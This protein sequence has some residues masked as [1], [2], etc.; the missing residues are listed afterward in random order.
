[1][2]SCRFCDLLREAYARSDEDKRAICEAAL[3]VNYEYFGRYAGRDLYPGFPI[4]FCPVCGR[5]YNLEVDRC[6]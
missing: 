5:Q 6:N 2:K 4:N 1:M 3:T